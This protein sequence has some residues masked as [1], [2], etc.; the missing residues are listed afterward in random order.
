MFNREIGRRIRARRRYL[1]MSQESVARILRIP[2]PSVTHMEDGTRKVT[3]YEVMIL[4]QVFNVDLDYFYKG[5][6]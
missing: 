3:V 1:E 6:L 2:R 4:C 5:T